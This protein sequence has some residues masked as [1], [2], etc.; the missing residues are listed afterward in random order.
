MSE[1]L[2]IVLV[3]DNKG[4]ARLI[5]EMIR[6]TGEAFTITW[7]NDGMRAI[8]YFSAGDD[9]DLILLD[10]KIPKVSGHE[11]LSFLKERSI[12]SRIPVIIMTGS[13]YQADIDKAMQKGAAEYLLKPMSMDEIENIT[14]ILRDIL[15]NRV[16]QKQGSKKLGV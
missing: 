14:R 15:V 3:E 12:P 6:D 13:T 16:K 5:E 9:A 4:D 10:L 1:P 2:K 7:L 11:V 8:E